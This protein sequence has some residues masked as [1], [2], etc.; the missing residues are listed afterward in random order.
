MSSKEPTPN[1]DIQAFILRVQR[2]TEEDIE[3]WIRRKV[4]RFISFETTS[5]LRE[6]F[7]EVRG[8]SA[9]GSPKQLESAGSAA[10]IL[11]GLN[12]VPDCFGGLDRYKYFRLYRPELHRAGR[13]Q[14]EELTPESRFNQQDDLNAPEPSLADLVSEYGELS[15]ALEVVRKAIRGRTFDGVDSLEGLKDR[16]HKPSEDYD[17]QSNGT[18]EAVVAAAT[19]AYNTLN[20]VMPDYQ[21]VHQPP[22][23]LEMMREYVETTDRDPTILTD[24]GSAPKTDDSSNASNRAPSLRGSDRD[25][26]TPTETDSALET[27]DSSNASSKARLPLWSRLVC[28]MSR[29]HRE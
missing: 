4:G 20:K 24:T 8:T 15:S 6:L 22:W 26:A 10:G 19:T 27:K 28:G 16:L 9:E 13:L 21:S 12:N 11:H 25:P 17:L 7:R 3:T 5:Q 14:G 18:M 2:M 1:P 29:K 23:P